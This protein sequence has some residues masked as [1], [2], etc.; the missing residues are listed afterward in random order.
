MGQDDRAFAPLIWGVKTSLVA[1]VR[2]LADGEIAFQA[3]AREALPEQAARLGCAQAFAFDPDPVGS[4]YDTGSRTGQLRFLGGVSFSGHFNTM[5]VEL[6]DPRLDLRDGT[7]TLSVRTNGRI[8]TPRWDA[9]A[10]ATVLPEPGQASGIRVD[11]ALTAAGRLLLGQQYPVGQS[12]A[13]ASV[14]RLQPFL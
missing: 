6:N 2:G 14:E 1:Y 10:S 4:H 5:R 3:P 13:P 12:L 11:L 7:G 8:G 9:I